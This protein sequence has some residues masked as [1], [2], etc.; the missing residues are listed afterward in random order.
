MR[1]GATAA[2]NG[3]KAWLRTEAAPAMESATGDAD[4]PAVEADRV[5]RYM[6]VEVRPE[7]QFFRKAVYE[8]YDGRCAISGCDIP[9]ALEAAHLRGRNW[10]DGQNNASDGILLRRDLHALYD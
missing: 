3:S 4:Y 1:I 8:A 2:F 9:E 6:N 7:Q 5:A 10:R